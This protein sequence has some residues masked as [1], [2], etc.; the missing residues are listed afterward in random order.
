MSLS[1]DSDGFLPR[2]LMTLPSSRIV[3]KPSPSLSKSW[4]ASRISSICSGVNSDIWKV[5]ESFGDN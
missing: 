3:M 4:K 5:T 1:S 2:D